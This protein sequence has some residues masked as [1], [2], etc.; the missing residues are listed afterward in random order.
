[1]RFLRMSIRWELIN[2]FKFTYEIRN[3]I[4]MEMIM[5]DISIVQSFYG[6]Q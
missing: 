5:Q 4:F 2:D 6:L 3:Y 1:M